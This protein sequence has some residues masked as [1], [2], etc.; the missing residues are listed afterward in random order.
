VHIASRN[1]SSSIERRAVSIAAN[2]VFSGSRKYAAT[3]SVTAAAGSGP[4]ASA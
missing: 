4:A 1:C 3:I 2:S